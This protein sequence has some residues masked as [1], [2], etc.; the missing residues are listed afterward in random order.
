MTRYGWLF[1]FPLLA[2][3]GIIVYQI[4][5]FRKNKLL[6]KHKKKDN[7]AQIA[8]TKYIRNLPEYKKARK[9]YNM[10]IVL[11]AVLYTASLGALTFLSA[12]PISV[13]ESKEEKENRDIMFC[14]DV[15]GSMTSYVEELATAF[16]DLVKRMDGERFGITIFDGEYAMLSP[17]SD[18]YTSLLDL[19]EGLKEKKT[20]HDYA[21][22]LA[23]YSGYSSGSSQIGAGLIGCADGFDRLKEIERSRIIIL[24]TDN[25]GPANPIAT[26]EQAAYYVRSNDITLYGLNIAD[27]RSQEDIDSGSTRYRSKQETEFQNAVTLTGGSYYAINKISGVNPQKIISQIMSQKAA[28]YEGAGQLVRNDNPKIAAIVSTILVVILIVIVWRLYL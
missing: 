13:T 5:L 21:Y 12:R 20:F 28:R 3:I 9:R 24:A 16:I 14:L 23:T 8:H 7:A 2:L 27:Y 4:L 17:L 22:S 10:L 19:L 11:A 25:Y 1:W 18:D 26:L 15:S 6:K